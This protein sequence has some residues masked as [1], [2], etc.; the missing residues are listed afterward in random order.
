MEQI[1][2][3]PDITEK[4]DDEVGK[5]VLGWFFMH[6]ASLRGIPVYPISPEFAELLRLRL[7]DLDEAVAPENIVLERVFRLAAKGEFEKAGEVFR[8][9]MLEGAGNLIASDELLTGS[10]KFSERQR[11]AG[12]S[13]K[14]DALNLVMQEII[15]NCPGITQKELLA[16]LETRK[17]CGVIVDV[18]EDE[19]V[20]L[21]RP[22]SEMLKV[23]PISGLKDRMTRIKKKLP[24]R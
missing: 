20:Y 17:Y 14:G 18:T 3:F 5:L 16:E 22:N 2:A 23:A 9:Q 10:R 11:K 12:A 6:Q 19:V 21:M 1:P 13:S 24:S 8:R 4:P 7:L 15:M